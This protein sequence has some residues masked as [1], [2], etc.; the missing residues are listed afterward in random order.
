[1]S[2]DAVECWQQLVKKNGDGVGADPRVC[3]GGMKNNEFQYRVNS[4]EQ[5]LMINVFN[6][7]NA[8]IRVAFAENGEPVFVAKDVCDVLGIRDHKQAL[9]RLDDDQKGGVLNT[10]T[11]G[12]TQKMVTV[13]E[14]G[15]YELILRSTKPEAR[16][17]RKWIT[18]DLL[19][20]LRKTGKYDMPAD[21]QDRLRRLTEVIVEKDKEVAAL[22]AKTQMQENMLNGQRQMTDILC[23]MIGDNGGEQKSAAQHESRKQSVKMTAHVITDAMRQEIERLQID[24]F[25]ADE[26]AVRTGVPLPQVEA[27]MRDSDERD[28]ETILDSCNCGRHQRAYTPKH[29]RKQTHQQRRR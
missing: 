7:G 28:L 19:P 6:F 27:I 2:N 14:S 3:L 9:E 25:N 22:M 10:P 18:S 11:F 12:G 20:K 29:H 17:F 8:P 4:M 13:T 1:M 16:A 24:G 21:F 5:Q 26:I 23:R 15:L